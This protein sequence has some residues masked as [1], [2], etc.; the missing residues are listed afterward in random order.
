[1]VALDPGS[2]GCV[3]KTLYF[4]VDNCT[5]MTTHPT[6]KKKLHIYSTLLGEPALAP[7]TA[8]FMP[9]HDIPPLRLPTPLTP[10]D[11]QVGVYIEGMSPEV[12]R[13]HTCPTYTPTRFLPL[14]DH[15][16]QSPLMRP[17]DMLRDRLLVVNKL[18]PTS[19]PSTSHL[20]GALGGQGRVVR[21]E[22]S[23][24]SRLGSGVDGWSWSRLRD[25]ERDMGIGRDEGSV[26]WF[27]QVVA[28]TLDVD[29]ME[30]LYS[31]GKKTETNL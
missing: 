7:F 14:T 23:A 25:H 28:G 29:Q 15:F 8:L 24:P 1:M 13:L 20:R 4:R 18:F 21:A 30:T 19:N 26:E 9:R 11:H 2:L 12:I 16:R 5:T 22:P 10:R 27:L 6:R 3:M 31:G 17:V